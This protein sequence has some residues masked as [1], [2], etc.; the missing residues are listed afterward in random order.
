MIQHIDN[1]E[2]LSVIHQLI[3]DTQDCIIQLK[4]RAETQDETTRGLLEAAST[5]LK[6]HI[7]IVTGLVE[8]NAKILDQ[9][10]TLLEQIHQLE[11]R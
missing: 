3:S 9:A 7:Q 6:L 5:L 10:N 4:N 1:T 11:K 8:Q 2:F